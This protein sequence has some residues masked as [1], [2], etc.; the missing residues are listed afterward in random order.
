MQSHI[1]K[2]ETIRNYMA[3]AFVIVE[4]Q[5]FHTDNRKEFVNFLLTNWLEKRNIKHILGGN[6]IQKVKEQLKV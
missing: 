4:P 2:A 1:K 6:I 5:M 3:Q